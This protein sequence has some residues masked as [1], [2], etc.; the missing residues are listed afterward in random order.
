MFLRVSGC[1]PGNTHR[2]TEDLSE[3][4][5]EG[6]HILLGDGLC[7]SLEEQSQIIG[8]TSLDEPVRERRLSVLRSRSP[9]HAELWYHAPIFGNDV[10]SWQQGYPAVADTAVPVSRDVAQL[11]ERVPPINGVERI[12]EQLLEPGLLKEVFR[13]LVLL[14]FGIDQFE[15]A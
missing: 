15:R 9:V 3:G 14:S 12:L 11:N 7:G 8:Q 13:F 5:P 6:E 4:I 10:L 1:C 2:H